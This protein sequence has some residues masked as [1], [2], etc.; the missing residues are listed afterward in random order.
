MHFVL[1]I[2]TAC[3]EEEIINRFRQ[4]EVG[5][6]SLKRTGPIPMTARRTKFSSDTAP[7]R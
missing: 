3:T 1:E 7:S 4:N 6:Y 5:V 2:D